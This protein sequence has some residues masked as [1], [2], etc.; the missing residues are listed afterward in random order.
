VAVALPNL[1]FCGLVIAY[2]AR[3]LGATAGDYLG[4][5]VLRPVLANA[6]PAAV[7]LALGEPAPTWPAIGAAIAAGLAPYA[8]VVAA[9]EVDVRTLLRGVANLRAGL[10]P[11]PRA[12]RD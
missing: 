2:T 7:W 10:R 1:A 3:L 8:A 5:A 12:P 4:T 9:C 11:A 6:V